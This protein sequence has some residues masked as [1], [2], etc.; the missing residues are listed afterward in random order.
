MLVARNAA[1]AI[2]R[3]RSPYRYEADG[4]ATKHYS[5][6]LDD[7]DLEFDAAYERA[8]RRWFPDKSVD[9]RWRAW[10]LTR[11]ARQF[12]GFPSEAPA[13]FA[14]FGTYRAGCAELVL[15][16]VHFADEQR[17]FLFDT[18][19]GIP[20]DEQ[21]ISTE[22]SKQF[23]TR[24]RDTSVEYV[25]RV[26]EPWRHRV[27]ICAGDVFQTL[28]DTETGPLAWVHL[29]LNATA[30]TL[31]ALDY[32]YPRVVPGGLLLFDDYGDHTFAPQR[33]QVDKFFAEVPEKAIALPTGQ[34]IVI[35]R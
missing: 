21:L 34:A 14:E 10:L 30:P 32:T 31:R 1:D 6:F 9:I 16:T 26:L 29:D 24:Y 28:E 27:E 3:R 15:S 18:F 19:T 17:F 4:F 22:R 33:R 5:P 11:F 8:I 25:E 20:Q 13:N 12:E 2:A 35:K 23:V 7:R